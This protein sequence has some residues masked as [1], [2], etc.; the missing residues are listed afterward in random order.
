MGEYAEM[1]IERE[2]NDYIDSIDR[3]YESDFDDFNLYPPKVS[4]SAES[5]LPIVDFPEGDDVLLRKDRTFD[6]VCIIVKK[7]DKAILFKIDK[8]FE[9]DIKIDF[10]FWL[11]KSVL[12]MKKDEKRIYRIKHWATITNIARREK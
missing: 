9:P 5:H 4:V 11:P 1:S 12:F 10:M 7:T 8:D 2:F 6:R 3:Y